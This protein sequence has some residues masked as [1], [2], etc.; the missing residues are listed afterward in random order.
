MSLV[1]SKSTGKPEGHVSWE[2][3]RKGQSICERGVSEDITSR[4]SFALVNNEGVAPV[5]FPLLLLR[6]FV[7]VRIG[8]DSD[9]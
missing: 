9:L 7:C 6:L 2:G 1:R 4:I 8:D 3:A 5:G